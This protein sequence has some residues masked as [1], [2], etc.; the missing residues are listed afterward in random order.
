[1]EVYAILSAY[2][3][4]GD[5][6]TK[7]ELKQQIFDDLSRTELSEEAFRRTLAE[8]NGI[9]Y[10]KSKISVSER[11]KRQIYSNTLRESIADQVASNLS[12]RQFGMEKYEGMK[13]LLDYSCSP[14]AEKKNRL[15][16]DTML[17]GNARKKSVLFNTL[18]NPL[19]EVNPA[20]LRE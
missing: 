9:R 19:L 1:M 17:G 5:Y 6:R 14:Q 16:S 7:N 8:E 18:T 13:H 10:E 20:P 15:I 4:T 2:E 12:T 3:R 11:D